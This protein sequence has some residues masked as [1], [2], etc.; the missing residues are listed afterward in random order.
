MTPIAWLSRFHGEDGDQLGFIAWDFHVYNGIP[1]VDMRDAQ[2]I[3]SA[4]LECIALL[5]EAG[6]NPPTS[7][8]EL[9]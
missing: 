1:V 6:I 7:A 9:T 3:Q 8:K 2:A 4:L 5:E